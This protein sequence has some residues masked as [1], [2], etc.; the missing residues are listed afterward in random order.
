[1]YKPRST[2]VT[3]KARVEAKARIR[4]QKVTKVKVKVPLLLIKAPKASLA[5]SFLPLKK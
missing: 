1:M 5:N 2:E 4:A 3:T